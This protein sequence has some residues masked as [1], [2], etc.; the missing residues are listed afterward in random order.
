MANSDAPKIWNAVFEAGKEFGIKPI[1][2]AARDTLRLEM[3]YCLYGNDINDTTSPI[4][5]GLG[6]ITKFN[7]TKDFINKP[8]LLKQ[9][10]EGTVR[11]LV[12]FEMVDK[13]IPRHGYEITDAA[14]KTIGE[15]TS[16][17]MGPSVKIPVG[18]GYVPTALSTEGSEI[19]IKIRDKILKAKVVKFP[20]YKG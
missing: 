8:Q 17:T 9:K 15:V 18:M 2:L 19:Y 3:G 6:W 13:G 20:F 4:E 16:G 10:K 14:G 1:G 7:D 12:G 11:K 5:A